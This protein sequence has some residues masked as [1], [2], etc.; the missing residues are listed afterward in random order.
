MI[1]IRHGE[2]PFNVAF[3]E[4]RR[5]PGVVDPGLTPEG[6]DQVAA[7]GRVLAEEAGDRRPARLVA[8]PYRR[9]LESAT[10][11]ADILDVPVSVEPLVRE[12]SVFACDIGTPASV[13]AREWRHLALDHLDEIWWAAAE[14]SE[15]ALDRRSHRF[16]RAMTAAPDWSRLCIVSHWGFIRSLTGQGLENAETHRLAAGHIHP[17]APALEAG[18]DE[19]SMHGGCQATLRES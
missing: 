14:E 15:E 11:L 9:T 7:A 2:T 6:R 5:D 1:L 12:R 4:T 3:R 19:A 16:H 13:L 10:I 8:S 18:R 17:R